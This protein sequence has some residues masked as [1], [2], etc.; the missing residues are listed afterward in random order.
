MSQTNWR[1]GTYRD[2]FHHLSVV[3]GYL[4]FEASKCLRQPQPCSRSLPTRC[5]PPTLW[6]HRST[7]P[8]HPCLQGT[9]PEP[10]SR[11]PKICLE[12]PNLVTNWLFL[13]AVST[14][15]QT[16]ILSCHQHYSIRSTGVELVNSKTCDYSIIL[17]KCCGTFVPMED[18]STRLSSSKK[19]S[20]D[21]LNSGQGSR[22]WRMFQT[23][24]L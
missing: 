20:S 7:K 19:A 16:G 10:G 12:P 14:E 2:C 22:T 21:F 9:G 11:N 5:L 23:T 18:T 15:T 6:Q 8:T 3:P 1:P 4:F 13:K 24:T 17:K